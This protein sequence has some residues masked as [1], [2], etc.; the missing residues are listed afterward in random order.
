M[1]WKGLRCKIAINGFLPDSSID[2]REL[3]GNPSTS[4]VKGGKIMHENQ[5]V[6]LLVENEELEG[7]EAVVVV[8]DP[9]GNLV[10]QIDTIIGGE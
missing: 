7:A 9:K 10:T 4:L 3:P 5:E 6:S 2:I 1:D 8:L